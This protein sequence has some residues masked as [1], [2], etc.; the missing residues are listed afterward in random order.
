MIHGKDSRDPTKGQTFDRLG[1][2]G[3]IQMAYD[4]WWAN[5]KLIF[6]VMSMKMIVHCLG[7][8][9]VAT[10]DV[11]IL[12]V[13]I[14]LL[15]FNMRTWWNVKEKWTYGRGDSYWKPLFSGS[16][17]NWGYLHD[18]LRVPLSP[19][20]KALRSEKYSLIKRFFAILLPCFF[21]RMKS[22]RKVMVNGSTRHGCRMVTVVG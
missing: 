8:W 20:K 11:S 22:G 3:K 16:M 15:K 1:L 4:E 14:L 2:P 6:W 7:W 19:P 9:Y 12:P 10:F 17:L 5:E 18:Y 13:D 21:D